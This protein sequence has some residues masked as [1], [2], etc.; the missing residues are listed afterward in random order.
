MTFSFGLHLGQRA[1]GE[2]AAL[3]QHGDLLGRIA[4]RQLVDE[5]HVVLH[6]HQRMACPRA[7]GTARRC[8]RSPRRSC[9]R[10]ARRAAAAS[11]PASA[12]CRSPA[13]ASGRARAARR[14]AAR[15]PSGGSAPASRRCGRAARRVRRKNSDARTPLSAFSASSRFSNTREVLEHRRLLELAADAELGDLVLAHGAAGRWSSRRT[16][17][18]VGPGLAGDDV[19]HRGLA[20][21]VRADDAAQLAG[22]DARAS[23][24][25]SALK[26]SKLTL[27]SSR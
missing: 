20:G 9:R 24:S 21:A 2:H 12:A 11:G 10:P 14:C 5:L 25:L 8:A 26:P 13:T 6:H 15:C 4:V 18:R 1:F 23:A 3:V 27:M 16:P 17:C 19:H 7:R 22:A